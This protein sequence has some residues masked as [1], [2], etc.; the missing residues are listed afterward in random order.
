MTVELPTVKIQE[1]THSGK[2][3]LHVERQVNLSEVEM[4][5]PVLKVRKRS[6]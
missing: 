2:L 4:G 3:S 5:R 6:L 1:R